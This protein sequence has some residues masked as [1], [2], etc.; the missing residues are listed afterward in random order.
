MMNQEGNKYLGDIATLL[1]ALKMEKQNL[2]R[3]LVLLRSQQ[4]VLDRISRDNFD[5][6]RLKLEAG[7]EILEFSPYERQLLEHLLGADVVAQQIQAIEGELHTLVS[8]GRYLTF[9]EIEGMLETIGMLIE[10]LESVRQQMERE[11]PSS[12]HSVKPL[13]RRVIRVLG[14][15]SLVG[16]DLRTQSW[17]SVA[18]GAILVLTIGHD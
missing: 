2:E 3:R 15:L 7:L 18:T 8:Q 5:L 13:M 17:P 11:Q 9:I 14:G 6:W 16:I 4:K 1:A 10:S 12:S